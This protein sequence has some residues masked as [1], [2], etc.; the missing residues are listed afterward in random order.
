MS[1]YTML[2]ETKDLVV[3]QYLDGDIQIRYLCKTQF[4]G[5]CAIPRVIYAILG[6][7]CF[8]QHLDLDVLHNI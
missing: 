6:F 1:I 5:V 2:K 4:L 7:G 3:M 8:V